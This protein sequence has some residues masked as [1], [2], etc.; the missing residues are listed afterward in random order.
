MALARRTA[1]TFHGSAPNAASIPATLN[2]LRDDERI[3]EAARRMETSTKDRR[4][5]RRKGKNPTQEIE[6]QTKK[7]RK[8][9]TYTF[10]SITKLTSS[11]CSFKC[12]GS[13]PN[14]RPAQDDLY[15]RDNESNGRISG[16]S[17]TARTSQ[18][19]L[20]NG[21]MQGRDIGV[22]LEHF[23]LQWPLRMKNM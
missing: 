11:F 16:E 12:V 21:D 9:G 13:D 17:R 4:K 18:T 8:V 2:G 14:A 10:A 6:K 3:T 7:L 22:R 20:T 1:E 23:Q 15:D 19:L 5:R